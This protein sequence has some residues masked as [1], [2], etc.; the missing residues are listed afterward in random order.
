MLVSIFFLV[1]L[2][3]SATQTTA[4]VISPAR[5]S[6]VD[7][8]YS[9]YQGTAL[10]NGISQWLGI[11]YAAAPLADLRFRAPRDPDCN[12]TL[13]VANKVRSDINSHSDTLTQLSLKH[14]AVCLST[15][16]TKIPSGYSEDCLFLDVY[17][18][19]ERT[20]L[21]PVYIF[22][23][24]GGFNANGNANY[25]GSGLITASGKNIVIVTFNYRVGPYGFLTSK[26]VVAN[27]D[28]NVGLKDQRKVFEWV[29]KYI[30]QVMKIL[31][32][33]YFAC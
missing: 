23:Q 26:E 5:D 30:Q 15:G 11:R 25:N 3:A 13:Q 19:T 31:N 27:G 16:V 21:L 6:I 28:T 10:P 9:R 4:L 24:K 7:L 14:G 2:V 22:I 29:Q 20:G 12:R 33:L 32:T 17:A 1:T 8:D 18:P